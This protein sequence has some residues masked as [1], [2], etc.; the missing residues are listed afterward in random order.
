VNS[1]FS[2]GKTNMANVAHAI[3]ELVTNASTWEAW[4]G[5]LP[6]VVNAAAS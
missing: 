5:K 6:V 4:R 2:P 1:V 3:C